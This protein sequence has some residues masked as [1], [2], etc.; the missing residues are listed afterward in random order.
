MKYTSIALMGIAAFML[1]GCG[2]QKSEPGGPGVQRDNTGNAH[3]AQS[4]NTFRIAVPHAATHIKQGQSMTI[5]ITID[6]GKNFHQD[7]KLEFKGAPQGVKIEPATTMVKGD[8]KEVNVKIEAD[9]TA[10][11][12]ESRITV[13][14]VP[15]REGAPTSTDFAVDVDKP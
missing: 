11:L 4:D 15:M 5:P 1:V 7:L 8:T 2:S 10:P 12:G 6:R 9:P 13:T 14:G 3:V